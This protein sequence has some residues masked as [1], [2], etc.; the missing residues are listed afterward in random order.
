MASSGRKRMLKLKSL[1]IVSGN[2]LLDGGSK[3]ITRPMAQLVPPSA[4]RSNLGVPSAVVP[5][6]RV[7]QQTSLRCNM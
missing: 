7:P 4:E 3:L 2:D 6:C 5:E 1:S